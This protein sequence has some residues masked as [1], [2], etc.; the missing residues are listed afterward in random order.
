MNKTL[1]QLGRPRTSKD[2]EKRGVRRDVDC[3]EVIKRI[4]TIIKLGVSNGQI[5][6]KL[7]VIKR[8]ISCSQAVN[9][10][11]TAKLYKLGY[12]I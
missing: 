3:R 1:E 5:N 8:L 6:A 9:I 11:S 10:D 12:H 2:T 7:F 4:T